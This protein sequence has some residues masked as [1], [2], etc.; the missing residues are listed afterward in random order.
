MNKSELST[1]TFVFIFVAAVGSLLSVYSIL[2]RSIFEL[3]YSKL[4]TLT[5]QFTLNKRVKKINFDPQNY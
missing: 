2:L 3:N 1:V 5:I 4:Y